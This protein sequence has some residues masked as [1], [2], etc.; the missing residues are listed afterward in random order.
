[1]Y[2][3]NA[4]AN[5]EETQL[6]EMEALSKRYIAF[7]NAGK[8]E[9]ECVTEAV[10]QAEA[11]GFRNL[12]EIVRAGGK[13][14]PGDRVYRAW[15]KKDIMLFIIGSKPMSEGM[16]ILGAHIDS[17][18]ID[19][20]QNP[21]YEEEGLAYLDTHYYGG[22][23]KYQWVTLPLAI[24][25]VVVKKDGTSLNVV[26]GENEKE[27]V[28]LVTDLLIHLSAK[29]LEAKAAKVIEGEKLD[30]LVGSRP[31]K[32]EEKDA[33]KAGILKLLEEKYG[34]EAEDFMSAELEIVPAGK[35]R[36]CGLD[37]SMIMAYGQD[38]RVCA[39]TSLKA[40]LETEQT[41]RTACCILVDKEEIGSVGATGM[42]SRFF[43]NAVAEILNL[44]EGFS[45]LKLRHVMANSTM[46]SSD[47]GAAYDPMYADVYDKKSSSFFGRGLVIKKHTGARGKSGSNDANAEY[48]ARLRKV[49]DDADVAFQMTEMGKIDAGGGGTIAY[50]LAEFGMEVI[51][52]GV[53][54]LCM[55][56]P[57]EVASKADVYEAFRAYKAFLKDMNR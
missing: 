53:A 18:R 25:G 30:I 17:P 55:H 42:H 4:W 35:A 29:Q 39:Y 1:M 2:K 56:A 15:M 12:D 27:P 43:E 23:K 50:I 3:K 31:L 37:R 9:R 14:V 33:V 52:G 21:L 13:L 26:I 36:E 5:Y 16:N 8:T 46:I 22:I 11:A 32:G 41:E 6:Q 20:K 51:D 57:W 40:M 48:I 28:L 47:V 10:K 45:E 38:D 49:F 34:M 44:L 54:V 7:L 19:V 24:H